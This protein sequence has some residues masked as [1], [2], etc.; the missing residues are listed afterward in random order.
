MSFHKRSKP[1]EQPSSRKKLERIVRTFRVA[2]G[3][4]LDALVAGFPES[5]CAAL[6][7][8]FPPERIV[9]DAI[10]IYIKAFETI[11]RGGL[12]ARSAVRGCSLDMIILVSQQVLRL[13]TAIDRRTRE[14]I[15]RALSIEVAQKRLADQFALALPLREQARRLIASMV[16][17][18][19]SFRQEVLRA[20]TGA[21]TG[22]SASS[23]LL[24]LGGLGRRVLTSD[25]DLVLQ[26]ARMFGLDAPYLDGLEALGR[27]LADGEA[28]L[29]RLTRSDDSVEESI[30]REAGLALHLMMQIVEAFTSAREIDKTVP[31]LR[32]VHTHRILRR[33]S[34][35]PPPPVPGHFA[36]VDTVTVGAVDLSKYLHGVMRVRR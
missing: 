36:K 33:L 12:E 13:A 28:E 9:D 30:R 26:R 23:A 6:G 3:N 27:H 34:K 5:E 19:P 17:D 8:C 15:E 32:P 2:A 10:D 11:Q 21:A 1:P 25:S 4:T 14:N 29:D 20:A 31:P 22:G 7:R 16:R 35:L 18:D 24:D